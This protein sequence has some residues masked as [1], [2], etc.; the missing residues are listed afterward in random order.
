MSGGASWFVG[1]SS[2]WPA[3]GRSRV[4]APEGKSGTEYLGFMRTA[5]DIAACI[6]QAGV[7][8]FPKRQAID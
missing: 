4:P 8:P 7:A 1:R 6:C 5:P 3:C 2:P